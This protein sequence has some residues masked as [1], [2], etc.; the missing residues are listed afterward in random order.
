MYP[1]CGLKR[2]RKAHGKRQD[3]MRRLGCENF[4][5]RINCNKDGCWQIVKNSGVEHGTDDLV[6]N[7]ATP[8]EVGNA[9][10]D[11]RV[12]AVMDQTKTV[13]KRIQSIRN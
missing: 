6:F 10:S 4:N 7:V 11:K 13:G 1:N 2:N 5:L 9:Q 8:C 12:V 3:A